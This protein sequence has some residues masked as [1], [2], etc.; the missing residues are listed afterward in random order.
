MPRGKAENQAALSVLTRPTSTDSS[1]ASTHFWRLNA[2][3]LEPIS[4]SAGHATRFANINYAFKLY[5]GKDLNFCHLARLPFLQASTVLQ[6]F[7]DLTTMQPYD[8]S[9][10]LFRHRIFFNFIPPNSHNLNTVFDRY[11]LDTLTMRQSALDCFNLRSIQFNGIFHSLILSQTKTV[12]NVELCV[13]K[14]VFYESFVFFCMFGCGTFQ[15]MNRLN[16]TARPQFM[17]GSVFNI[18]SDDNRL[19]IVVTSD[20]APHSASVHSS[21][22][23]NYILCVTNSGFSNSIQSA[24]N[25]VFKRRQNLVRIV[26]QFNFYAKIARRY[27][28]TQR[29]SP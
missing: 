4:R 24:V 1:S 12:V 19:V 9:V 8:L 13:F 22:F 27:R 15:K 6:T 29:N 3:G 18:R 17:I 23:C 5:A 28:F 11:K 26:C 14:A 20:F 25:S 7:A 21:G 10:Y 16:P 2:I